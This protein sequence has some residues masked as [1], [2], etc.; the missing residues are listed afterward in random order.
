MTYVGT[1]LANAVYFPAKVIFAGGGAITSGVVYIATLGDE[2]ATGS[3]WNAS[4]K[5][6]YLLSPRMIEG[7]EN[8]R[9]AG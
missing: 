3:V 6:D 7:R 5:G 8:V 4:T 9:F 1:V 2:E